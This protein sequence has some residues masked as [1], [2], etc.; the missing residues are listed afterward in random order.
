VPRHTSVL[1]TFLRMLRIARDGFGHG[2]PLRYAAA[3][4]RLPTTDLRDHSLMMST[5]E[6]VGE[7]RWDE[8]L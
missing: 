8:A 3:E 5:I 4:K 6:G 7:T 1:S 2:L